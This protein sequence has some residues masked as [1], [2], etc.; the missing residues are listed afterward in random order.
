M[1]L[2]KQET[3][4]AVNS[5][6]IEKFLAK[7]DKNGPLWNGTPCWDW[8]GC[9]NVKGYGLFSCYKLV[10]S[11][12]FSYEIFSGPIGEGLTIDHLCRRRGCVN[13]L[14]LE[15][16]TRKENVLRGIGLTAKN[17]QKTHCLR[18]HSF[19]EKNTYIYKGIR[20]CVTCRSESAK[21]LANKIMNDMTLRLARNKK[22]RERRNSANA[23]GPY[24]LHI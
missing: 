24:R 23:R 6:V 3:I 12:R 16:V 2:S 13:P 11:H 9:K 17:H 7:V 19:D 1:N 20:G 18:G 21:K 4:P 5:S 15:V 14:H 10:Q 8:K 22:A